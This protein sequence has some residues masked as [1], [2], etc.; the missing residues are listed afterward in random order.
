MTA[1]NVDRARRDRDFSLYTTRH[2]VSIVGQGNRA[3]E[4]Y[5]YVGAQR[6]L[7]KRLRKRKKSV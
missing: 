7:N 2:L 3:Y 5:F 4:H 6:E 1:E